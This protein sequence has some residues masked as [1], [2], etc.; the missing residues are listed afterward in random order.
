MAEESN[1]GL[2]TSSEFF[3]NLKPEIVA[4]QQLIQLSDEDNSIGNNSERNTK[5]R[6]HEQEVEQTLN[7]SDTTLAKIQEIFGKDEV[8]GP[9]KKKQRKYR[10]LAHIYK[11]TSPMYQEGAFNNKDNL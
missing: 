3:Q 1:L 5:G 8:Y 6:R 7:I 11:A 9:R 4:A 10:S 2:V